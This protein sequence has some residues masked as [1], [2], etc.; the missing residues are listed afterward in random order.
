MAGLDLSEK[1]WYFAAGLGAGL[2]I[3]ILVVLQ[4]YVLKPMKDEQVKLRSSI[5][6]LEA[7]KL[8]LGVGGALV[9]GVTARMQG[10]NL[11]S[12][13]FLS[14]PVL[15]RN[16]SEILGTV[17]FVIALSK[18][19]LATLSSVIMSSP[20]LVTLGAAVILGEHVG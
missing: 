5:Q 13:A 8:I 9:F 14:K 11:A 16:A 1:P 10:A 19:E 18:I 20:L 6:A 15:A 3:V 7:L 12:P 4:I 17:C 2:G